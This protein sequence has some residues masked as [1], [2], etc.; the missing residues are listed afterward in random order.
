MNSRRP[1]PRSFD[2]RGRGTYTSAISDNFSMRPCTRIITEQIIA[3]RVISIH[4]EL[5]LYES[6]SR[7]AIK[8]SFWRCVCIRYAATSLTTTPPYRRIM[9]ATSQKENNIEKNKTD[10]P[11]VI[12]EKISWILFSRYRGE[13][14]KQ[15]NVRDSFIN[16]H[17]SKY[18]VK[19]KCRG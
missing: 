1:S 14:K 19:L 15:N 11:I 12:F 2:Y 18:C 8:R 4:G 10:G 3:G 16:A 17:I 5:P 13:F 7:T 9:R 6:L